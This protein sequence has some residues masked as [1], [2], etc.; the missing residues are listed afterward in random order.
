MSEKS[1]NLGLPF[2]LPAQAQKHVTHNEALRLI[3]AILQLTVIDSDQTQAPASPAN[4]DRHIVASGA[5]GAW[6]GQDG[7]IAVFAQEAWEFIEPQTGWRAFDQASGNDLVFDGASWT[8]TV[9]TGLATLGVNA[10]ADAY[11][12]FA[13]S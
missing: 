3:D 8:V 12:R 2:I 6:T 7:F 13:V 11:N 9:L 10:E 1:A 4:G 5:S